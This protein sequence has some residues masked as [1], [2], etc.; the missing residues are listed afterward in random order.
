[1]GVTGQISI[2]RVG[3][4]VQIKE[5]EEDI[6][7][8]FDPNQ[9]PTLQPGDHVTLYPGDYREAMRQAPIAIPENVFLTILPGAVVEYGNLR[10]PLEQ[11]YTYIEGAAQNIAD[12]NIAHQYTTQVEKQS[13]RVRVYPEDVTS[14]SGASVPFS[15]FDNV[16]GAIGS[17][18]P[19]SGFDELAA[20]A[21]AAEPGDTIIVFPGRYTPVR[22][23]FVNDTTW[24][25]LDGAIVEYTP[26]FENVYPHAL[27]DDLKSVDGTSDPGGKSLSVQGNGEF[28]IGTPNPQP[29][30]LSDFDSSTVSTIDWEG[31]HMYSLLGVN[32]SSSNVDFEA[33]RIEMKDYIDGA[34][35]LSGTGE[36]NIDVE[37]VDIL[38]S[39][40]A[41]STLPTSQIPAFAVFNGVRPSLVSGN[42]SVEVSKLNI[43]ASATPP[44][45]F[46]IGLNHNSSR[47]EPF[48]GSVSFQVE[49]C[50]TDVPQVNSDFIRFSDSSSPKKLVLKS[51]TLLEG[52]AGVVLQG[53]TG[54][55]GGLPIT[56][57][58]IKNS[59]IST[60]NVPDLP[61][62]T[63]SGNPDGF[64]VHFS[65][66]QFLTGEDID[67]TASNISTF[68]VGNLTNSTDF[69]IKIYDQ[70]FADAP[71]EDFD[72]VLHDELNGISWTSEVES[73][74]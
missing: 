59:E 56:K 43:K 9:S 42:V 12:L 40:Q 65:G 3:R 63:L 36:V 57:L 47:R 64:D 68:S 29:S 16:T 69:D 39:V 2:A 37:T 51:S 14:A 26:S 48:E 32:N 49:E 46:A 23:L 67:F 72:S 24:H 28:I 30:N 33:K 11:R 20:A 21:D 50:K 1:M 10:G 62:I 18:V 70:C 54:P 71:I 22:N 66:S 52:N 27:F 31:W 41:D 17:E 73:L 61:P 74:S 5:R 13:P 38:D 45:Y 7:S 19:F 44:V 35:K 34:V 15:S 55:T 25:F 58:I 53:T 6:T 60:E 4:T 8:V